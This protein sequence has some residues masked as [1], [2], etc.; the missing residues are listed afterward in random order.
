MGSPLIFSSLSW[1]A[2]DGDAFRNSSP[3]L[4]LQRALK[5]AWQGANAVE[6]E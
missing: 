6:K 5:R 4:D 2:D 3:A 1:V